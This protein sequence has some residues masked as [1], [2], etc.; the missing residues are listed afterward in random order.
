M[1]Y[2]YTLLADSWPVARKPHR[3]IWC[4]QQIEAGEKYRCERSVYDGEMQDHAW[5]AECDADAAEQFRHG[6]DEFSPYENERP[7]K[8]STNGVK[9]SDGGD[10]G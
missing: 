6:E 8:L 3:C 5:H 4:G 9:A 10:R 2:G 1:S 7:P